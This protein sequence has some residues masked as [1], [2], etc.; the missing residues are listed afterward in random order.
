MTVEL[1][2]VFD[3]LFSKKE[4]MELFF[5]FYIFEKMKINKNEFV[6]NKDQFMKFIDFCLHTRRT[7]KNNDINVGMKYFSNNYE[8][9][10]KLIKTKNINQLKKMIYEAKGVGQKI[11]SFILE[12]IYL[13]SNYRN[14]DI[15]KVLFVPI[16]THIERIFYECLNA[17]K[18]PKQ[19]SKYTSEEFIK[20]QNALNRFTNNRSRLYFDYLWFI[21]KMFCA[22]TTTDNEKFNKGYKLCNYCWIKEYCKNKNKWL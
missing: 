12:V 14:S 20:F 8:E 4:E 22:K 13:Y 11:G 17:R 3:I 16:D 6:D 18:I 2:K 19:T 21:G 1:S 7:P 5:D 15:A 10:L 9:I